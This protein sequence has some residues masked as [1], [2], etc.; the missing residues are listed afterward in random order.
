MSAVATTS[1]LTLYEIEES[2][3]ALVD[4]DDLVSDEQRQEFENTLETQLRTAVDKRESVGRFIRF[5]DLNCQNCDV[6]IR[7][8]QE[9]KKRWQNAEARMR[10]YVQR[11][12]ESMGQDERG[13]F[14]K[15]EGRT[16]TFSLR[17]NPAQLDI[18][19]TSSV[20]DKYQDINVTFPLDVWHK[21]VEHAGSNAELGQSLARSAAEAK[22][23]LNRKRLREDIE[24]GEPVNGADLQFSFSLVVR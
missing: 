24:R 11:V 22:L 1:S 17:S 7:R 14:R 18:A 12:I 20:P 4:T 16:V 6:E 15:L 10:Q 5:C 19:D 8:L 2:L 13:K 21:L 3:L 9:R 23:S